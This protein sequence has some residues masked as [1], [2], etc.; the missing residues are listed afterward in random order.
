MTTAEPYSHALT[1]HLETV[2][3]VA[4]SPKG[5]TLTSASYDLTAR[6]WPLDAN[7]AIDRVCAYSGGDLTGE[8][9][10]ELVPGLEFR[11]GCGASG[12]VGH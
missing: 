3:S 9:W 4:F 1:G 5:D 2:T 11:D 10:G 6:V 8:V 7:S 12:M